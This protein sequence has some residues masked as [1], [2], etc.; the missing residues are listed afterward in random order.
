M[1]KVIDLTHAITPA[2]PVYPGTQP[3]TIRQATT[4][5][6][7]G[8]AEKWIGMYSHTG[9]HIDAP[10][11]MLPN[12]VTLDQLAIDHFIGRAWVLDVSAL[13]GPE[14]GMAFLESRAE[15]LENVEFVLFHTGWSRRWNEESYFTG[16]PV[17]SAEAARWLCRRGLKGVGFDAMSADQVGDNLFVNHLVFFEAGLILIENLTGLEPLL[18]RRFLFSCLPL[19]L[20]QADGSPVRAVAMVDCA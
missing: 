13:A 3:P 4:V 5:A 7:D 17:L 19:K 6:Q 2:M 1:M 20:E 16:F 12:A 9:T 11:H 8:F 15:E 18:G 14:I 10:A